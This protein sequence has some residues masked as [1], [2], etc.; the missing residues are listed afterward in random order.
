MRRIL[1]WAVMVVLAASSVAAQQGTSEMRGRVADAQGG[2]LPGVSVILT[3]QANGTFRETISSADGSFIASGMVPGTYKVTA[4]LGGFKKFERAD[5]LLEV[6]R[7]T[8]LDMAMEVGGIEE[9]VSVTAESPIVD[10]TSKESGGNISSETLVKLPSVNGNFIGFVGLLPGIVPSVSTESF[11]SDSIASACASS[12]DRNAHARS[13]QR[14]SASA[15]WSAA[16]APVMSP[17]VHF[18]R[19]SQYMSSGRSGLSSAR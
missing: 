4:E 19:P 1:I 15:S 5:V 13:C 8:S 7:T 12:R 10:L 9:S 18:A 16:R 3:N 14:G 2:A 11:G 17:A 6:G